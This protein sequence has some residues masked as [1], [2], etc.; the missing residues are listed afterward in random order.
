MRRHESCGPGAAGSSAS[1]Q[2]SDETLLAQSGQR[3]AR[4]SPRASFLCLSHH[5]PVIRRPSNCTKMA[6]RRG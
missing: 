3:P 1:N 6:G 4:W 2:D 5:R